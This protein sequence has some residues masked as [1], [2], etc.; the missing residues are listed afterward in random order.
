MGILASLFDLSFTTFVTTRLM[1]VLYV[2]CIAFA[3]LQAMVLVGVGFFV[4]TGAGLI[5]LFAVAPLAFLVEV[6]W[7]R[8]AIECLVVVFRATEQ[9]TEIA[10]RSHEPS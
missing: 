9:V 2:F 5:A 1:K 6:L 7:C 10:R 3:A 4:S 8:V